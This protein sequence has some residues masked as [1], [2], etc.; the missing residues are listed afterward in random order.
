VASGLG[1]S[2][3]PLENAPFLPRIVSGRVVLAR[4]RWNLVRS[5]IKQFV[6]S[7]GAVQFAAAQQLRG[8]RR[9]PRYV[10]LADGDNELVIDLDN[11]LSV[12]ALVHLVKGL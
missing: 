7:G 11:V 8:Q 1:W 2:W 9:I 6:D 10:A 4:A 12:D 5:E 3:G